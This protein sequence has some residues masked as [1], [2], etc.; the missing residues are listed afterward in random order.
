MID[1]IDLDRCTGCSLCE[2]ACPMDIIEIRKV[3]YRGKKR[4]KA[5]VTNKMECVVCYNCEMICT[6]SAIEV[7]SEK[8]VPHP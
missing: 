6:E 7:G 3:L 1:Q 4:Q 5:F 8:P 2:L